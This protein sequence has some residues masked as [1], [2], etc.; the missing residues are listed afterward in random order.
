[1]TAA[2]TFEGVSKRFGDLVILDKFDMTVQSGEKVVVIGPSG[3]GKS[4]LLRILMTL[5]R[6]SEGRVTIEGQTLC[7]LTGPIDRIAQSKAH[8]RKMRALVGMS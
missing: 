5:E 3:S 7:D 8:L 6:V 4:T 2:V 1:M